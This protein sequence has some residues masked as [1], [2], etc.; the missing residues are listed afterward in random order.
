MRLVLV[1]WIDAVYHDLWEP[2]DDMQ[3]TSMRVKSVEWLTADTPDYLTV[4]PHQQ[5]DQA[6]GGISIRTETVPKHQGPCPVER[7]L[8]V[9]AASLLPAPLLSIRYSP[10]RKA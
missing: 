7:G 4:V 2:L 9:R 1:E 5:A 10:P 8:G 6:R 3:P